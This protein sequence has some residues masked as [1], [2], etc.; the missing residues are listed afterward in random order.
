MASA[1][2]G[3]AF[4]RQGANIPDKPSSEQSVSRGPVMKETR[5]HWILNPR[6]GFGISV[7]GDFLHT[8]SREGHV[9][10]FLFALLWPESW[11]EGV[12]MALKAHLS[13]LSQWPEK[14]A[15]P[16]RSGC[17]AEDAQASPAFCRRLL[18]VSVQGKS[19][20]K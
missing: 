1:L 11:L 2:I 6:R 3:L 19:P 8:K 12:W 18:R 7:V 15:S 9:G 13:L 16:L 5:G 20:T 14:G 4:G 17:P 10:M